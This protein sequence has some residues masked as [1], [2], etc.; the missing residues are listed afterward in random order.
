LDGIFLFGANRETHD[1]PINVGHLNAAVLAEIFKDLGFQA[2]VTY[3]CLRASVRTAFAEP[4]SAARNA[5]TGEAMSPPL[6]PRL[7][8]ERESFR[9]KVDF[10]VL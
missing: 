10:E 4:I 7:D 9:M 5:N 8:G 6:I 3:G 2:C 1:Q